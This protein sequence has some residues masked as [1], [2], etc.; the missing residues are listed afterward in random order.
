MRI[1]VEKPNEVIKFTDVVPGKHKIGI[2]HGDKIG[3]VDREGGILDIGSGYHTG[4]LSE[5]IV[6]MAEDSHCC[7]DR[8]EMLLWVKNAIDTI[9]ANLKRSTSGEKKEIIV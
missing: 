6:A 7:V 5:G 4:K 2:R 1:V 9:E 3:I 8:T